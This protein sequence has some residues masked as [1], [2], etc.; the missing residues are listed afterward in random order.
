MCSSREE[1]QAARVAILESPF[2]APTVSLV[3]TRNSAAEPEAEASW[4]QN[5]AVGFLARYIHR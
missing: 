1:H 3:P 2:L 4:A 5:S